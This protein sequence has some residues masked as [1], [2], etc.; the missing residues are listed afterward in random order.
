M[1]IAVWGIAIIAVCG[2]VALTKSSR[3]DL[4]PV[5][6]NAGKAWLNGQDLY[7]NSEF[8]YRYSPLFAAAM[9]PMARLPA[10]L[11]SISWRLLSVFCFLAALSWTCRAGVPDKF[12]SEKSPLIFLLILPLSLGNLNNGQANLLVL[13]ALLAAVAAVIRSWWMSAAIVLTIAATIKIYPLAIA[14]LLGVMFPRQ[15]LWRFALCLIVAVAL[16]FALQRIDYVSHQYNDWLLYLRS[17]DRT[18]RSLSEWYSDLRLLFRVWFVPL[19]TTTY[20][21]IQLAAGAAIGVVA[22]V[23]KIRHWPIQSLIAWIFSLSCCW[24]TLFGPATESATYVLIAPAT[25]WIVGELLVRGGGAIETAWVAGIYGLQLLARMASWFGGMKRF[26]VYASPL[27]L[28]ALLLAAYL[29]RP[30]IFRQMN[31]R[32]RPVAAGRD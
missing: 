15:L 6:Q 27:A 3:Q 16:P 30:A 31:A 10:K 28:S 1:V 5:Y 22:V 29:L 21:V 11:A 20:V 7:R 17:E 32:T 23:G 2:R 18:S 26:G 4:F 24:M 14:L 13:G 12:A 9:A 25:A 8:D 19:S